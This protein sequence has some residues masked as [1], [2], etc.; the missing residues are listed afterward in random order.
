[1]L[2]NNLKKKK[3]SINKILLNFRKKNKSFQIKLKNQ[4]KKSILYKKKLMEI[5]KKLWILSYKYN[6]LNERYKKRIPKK[7]TFQKPMRI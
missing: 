4:L 5:Y 3:H 1:M 2:K 7:E 6:K